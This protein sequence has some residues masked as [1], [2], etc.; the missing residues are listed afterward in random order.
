MTTRTAKKADKGLYDAPPTAIPKKT[1]A[2]K[3]IAPQPEADIPQEAIADE[4]RVNAPHQSTP[5]GT[6]DDRL[7]DQLVVYA[8]VSDV[9]ISALESA[10]PETIAAALERTRPSEIARNQALT[11]R[12]K[13]LGVE[14]PSKYDTMSY[15]DSSEQPTQRQVKGGFDCF[16]NQ[17]DFIQAFPLLLR[18]AS[19][20]TAHPILGHVHLAL[21]PVQGQLRMTANNLSTVI[22]TSIMA[23]VSEAG[24][25]TL[26]GKLLSDL[27]SQLPDESIRL[28]LNPEDQRVTVTSSA[29]VHKI[30][31]VGVEE[32]PAI[33]TVDESQIMISTQQLTEAI[34]HILVSVSRDQSKLVLTCGHLSIDDGK[35]ELASTDGH[36]LSVYT[37]EEVEKGHSQKFNIS[38]E[39]LSLLSRILSLSK[40][41]QIKMFYGGSKQPGGEL[42]GSQHLRFETLDGQVLMTRI[43]E[44]EYPKYRQL[45]PRH[46]PLFATINRRL[47]LEAAER[48]NLFSSNAVLKMEFTGS[49]SQIRLSAESEKMGVGDESFGVEFN[50]GD[51]T[52]CFNASYL[53]QILR[54]MTVKSVR[55]CMK[56][57]T[58]PALIVPDSDLGFEHLLMPVQIREN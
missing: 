33:P 48:V 55:L 50:G 11:G 2:K 16:L 15:L 14:P 6:V 10:N 21:D 36:R 51:F 25:F 5:D 40:S 54:V 29:G 34:E 49:T 18:V 42:F 39:S 4:I 38:H 57:P 46:L 56:N 47:L 8:P 12:M 9:F 28:Q 43:Y 13:L 37:L 58:N 24:T 30:V 53:S 44:A 52:I 27:I 22:Q 23:D 19:T 1:R 3:A 32:F 31:G 20:S 35:C 41:E 17:R 26:P 7:V 45:M